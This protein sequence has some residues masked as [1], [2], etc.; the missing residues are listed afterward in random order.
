MLSKECAIELRE[1]WFPHLSDSGLHRLIEL[2]EK[3][4]PTLLHGCFTKTNTMGCL[5]TQAG[6]HHPRTCQLQHDAGVVWLQQIVGL[7]P[8]RSRVIAEWDARGSQDFELRQDLLAIFFE[9]KQKRQTNSANRIAGLKMETECK[10]D[11]AY[12]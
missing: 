9:E 4:S 6:W 8:G 5:A 3:G 1:L 7:H 10:H 12:A 11:S 2:L